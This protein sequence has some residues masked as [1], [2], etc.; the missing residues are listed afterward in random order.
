[1]LFDDAYEGYV[2]EHDRLPDS[3]FYHCVNTHP[4]L[5]PVKLDGVSKELLCYGA[6][7]GA[8]TFGLADEWLAK[9]GKKALQGELDEKLGGMIRATVS[10]CNH[11][12]QEIVA[13]FLAD[14][15]RLAKARRPV[16][17]DLGRRARVFREACQILPRSITR[18]DPFQGGFFAFINLDGIDATEVA[19]CLMTEHRLGVVPHKSAAGRVNGI[20]VAWSG[21]RERDMG[22]VCEKILRALEGRSD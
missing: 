11:A 7:L 17:N 16:V 12:E 21:L 22:T 14:P 10:N 15:D 3:L 4:R 13:R 9:A 2:Y 1:M 5:L 20:R 6:R 18:L 8:I 19:E